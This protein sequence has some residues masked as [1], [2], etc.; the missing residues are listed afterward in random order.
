MPGRS[1]GGIRLGESPGAVRAALGTFYGSVPRLSAPDVVLHL[2]AVRQARPRGRV[3]GRA[4]L[5]RLH[6]LAACGLARAAQA[7][8]RHVGA[9]RAQAHRRVAHDHLHRLRRAR[10]RLGPGSHGLLRL[11]AAGSG[12]S[13]SS[14]AAPLPADEHRAGGRRARRAATRRRRPPHAGPHL[15]DPRRA[16]RRARPREGGVLPARRRLQVPRRVQQ[17]LVPRRGRAA[18]G[19]PRLLVRQP[20]AGRRHRRGAPRLAR[21]DR[22]ARGRAGREARR[23]ARLRRRGRAVR[24]LDGEPRGDR[25]PAGGGARARARQALRRPARHG[26]PGD[27]RARAARGRA[28]ARPAPRADQRRRPHRR[29]RDRG[30]GTAAGDPSR[31]ESSPRQATTRAVPSPPASAFASTSRRLSP[32]DCRRPSPGS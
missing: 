3:H 29:L 25:R 1:L 15:A 19:R 8:L 2:R 17:D 4:G 16:D 5:G 27:G 24:P 6:A 28:G 31:R 18:A 23:D 13:A 20:R 9:R 26:R 10:P 14:V 21:D 12:A 32:T 7:R 11:R 30:E 22:H